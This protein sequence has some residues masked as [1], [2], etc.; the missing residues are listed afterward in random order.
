MKLKPFVATTLLMA[1]ALS[2]HTVLAAEQKDHELF[3][4]INLTS[5]YVW[6]GVTQTEDFT[7]APG[8]RMWTLGIKAINRTGMWASV[9]RLIR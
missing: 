4:N 7:P 2:S 8:S 6:R 1:V 9:S 3:A 5:N